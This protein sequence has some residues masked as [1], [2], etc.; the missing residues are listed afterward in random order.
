MVV[1]PPSIYTNK[2]VFFCVFDE[3]DAEKGFLK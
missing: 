3:I 2:K 1:P